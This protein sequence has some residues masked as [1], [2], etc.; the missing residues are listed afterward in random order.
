MRRRK[1]RQHAVHS[2]VFRCD[3]NPVD[4]QILVKME[5]FSSDRRKVNDLIKDKKCPSFFINY[6][7][8]LV[9]LL[10]HNEDS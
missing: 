10:N 3:P 8:Y 6:N 4:R 9:Y 1:W 7:I 5:H 2:N